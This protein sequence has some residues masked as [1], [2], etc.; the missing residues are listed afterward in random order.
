VLMAVATA[1][2]TG[3]A[4]LKVRAVQGDSIDVRSARQWYGKRFSR[5]ERNM[6]TAGERGMRFKQHVSAISFF[7]N[8]R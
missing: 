1:G 5:A 3:L 7:A 2:V 6:G 8:G 4:D